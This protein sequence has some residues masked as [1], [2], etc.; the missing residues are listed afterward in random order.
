MLD[1]SNSQRSQF[2]GNF[3]EYGFNNLHNSYVDFN[4]FVTYFDDLSYNDS[5]L[6]NSTNFLDFSEYLG[7]PIPLNQQPDRNNQV[8]S[9]ITCNGRFDKQRRKRS[10]RVGGGGGGGHSKPNNLHSAHCSIDLSSGN[11]A[12]VDETIL[13]SK[14]PSSCPVSRD[15][16]WHKCR[17][18]WQS[19]LDKVRWADFYFDHNSGDI[20][21]S[22]DISDDNLSPFKVKSDARVPVSKDIALETF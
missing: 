6:Y 4:N 10:S 18:D 11:V 3:E 14:G 19:F 17:L 15:I 1:H 16:N 5:L 13:V 2:T 9:R 20:S 8:I 22:P 7:Q 21:D 12:P